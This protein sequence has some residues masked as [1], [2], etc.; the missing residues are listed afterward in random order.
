MKR[1]LRSAVSAVLVIGVALAFAA[2]SGDRETAPVPV[3]PQ[4]DGGTERIAGNQAP[5]GIAAV[6]F[7]GRTLRFWPYSG[8]DFSGEPMSPINLVFV[9]HASPLEIRAALLG[10][11]GSRYGWP[12]LGFPAVD[13]R[14]TDG[15]DEMRTTYVRGEGWVESLIQLDCGPFDQGRFHLWLFPVRAPFGSGVWTLGSVT[16]EGFIPGGAFNQ[17]LTWEIARQ[18]VLVD[19]ERSGFLDAGTPYVTTSVINETPSFGTIPALI[20]NSMPPDL[21]TILDG[22]PMPVE[23]DVPISSDGCAFLLNVTGTP[24]IV[25]GTFNVSHTAEM[26]TAFRRPPCDPRA[27]EYVGIMGTLVFTKQ[28]RV[29]A[30]GNYESTSSVT[31]GYRQ[32]PIPWIEDPSVIVDCARPHVLREGQSISVTPRGWTASSFSTQLAVREGVPELAWKQIVIVSG[33][34]ASC[35]TQELCLSTLR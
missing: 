6:S 31:G 29:Q 14:W 8:I 1:T 2:C 9:G 33:L 21:A 7:Q 23:G 18:I 35:Q 30:G 34:C 26:G 16:F 27:A 3:A 10:V 5:P 25:P 28:V 20:Y 32:I 4:K 17:D 15:I 12:L 13:W 19:L 11:E 22:P 24:A